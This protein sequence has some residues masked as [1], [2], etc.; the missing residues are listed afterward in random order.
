MGWEERSK[1]KKAYESEIIAMVSRGD[2]TPDDGDALGALNNPEQWHPLPESLW[3]VATNAPGIIEEGF[4]T[5]EQLGQ[6][7]GIGPRRRPRP[8]WCRSP[9]ASRWPRTSTRRCWRRGRSPLAT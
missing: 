7:S 2:I 8:T 1:A 4:K 6:S 5:R 3:H 9:P